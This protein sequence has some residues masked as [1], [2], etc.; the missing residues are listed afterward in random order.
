MS[1]GTYVLVNISHDNAYVVFASLYQSAKVM[2]S[3]P[4]LTLTHSRS[5]L[6][7]KSNSPNPKFFETST[8]GASPVLEMSNVV[9][10]RL[11]VTSKSSNLLLDTLSEF[12]FVFR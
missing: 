9:K 8:A 1:S 10:S 3:S 6:E 2:S 12:K 11:F 4:W 7:V 5:G